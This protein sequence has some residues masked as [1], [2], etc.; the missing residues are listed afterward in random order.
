[1]TVAGNFE[2]AQDPGALEADRH[3]AGIVVGAGGIVHG[4]EIIAVARVVVSRDQHD[5]LRRR[6]IRAFQNRVHIGEARGDA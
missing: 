6:G 3:S 4:V 2:F 1:M 5:A